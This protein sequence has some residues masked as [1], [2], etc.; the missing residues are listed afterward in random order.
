MPSWETP[1][2][3]TVVACCLS[4]RYFIGRGLDVCRDEESQVFK[5]VP[6]E[7]QPFRKTRT[8]QDKT[9][10]CLT[11][12]SRG[13]SGQHVWQHDQTSCP[14][15][16]DTSRAGDVLFPFRAI[17]IHTDSDMNR[18]QTTRR[19]LSPALRETR[20]TADVSPPMYSRT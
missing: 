10:R 2:C 14:R 19:E 5:S 18:G 20:P 17:R 3:H 9:D 13:T 4:T 1:R 12:W 15:R 8:A 16:S 7:V 11:L 6:R